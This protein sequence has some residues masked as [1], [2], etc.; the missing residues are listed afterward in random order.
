MLINNNEYLDLVQHIKE[1]IKHAQ[2]KAVLSVNKQLIVLY[3]NIGKLIN[4]HK[5]WGSKFIENLSYDIKLSFPNSKG[6]SVRNLK[7]MSKFADTYHDEQFVQ[8][9]VAQIPWGHIVVL[10]DKI[11]NDKTRNWYIQKTLENG[12]SRNVLVHQIESKLYER[13]AIANKVNNFENSLPSPM[14]EL[15]SETMKDPYIFD[16]IPFKKDIVERDI[17]ML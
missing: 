3:Y 2:Y 12:W 1:E 13:Q 15:A 11:L 10:L 9:A 4:K 17:E 16:F 14:R 5:T 8:Q 6:Y 7:Y